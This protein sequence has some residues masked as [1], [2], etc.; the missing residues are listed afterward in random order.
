MTFL[1]VF[2]MNKILLLYITMVIE[3]IPDRKYE[4]VHASTI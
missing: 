4:N 2:M 1:A 3:S